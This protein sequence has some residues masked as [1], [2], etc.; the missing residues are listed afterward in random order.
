MIF[1]GATTPNRAQI[2]GFGVWLS[3]L[4]AVLLWPVIS[5]TGLAAQDAA[6]GSTKLETGIDYPKPDFGNTETIRFLTDS[7]Y[8]PFNYLDEEGSLGGFNVDLARAICEELV[9][10][11]DVRAGDWV[12]LIATLERKDTDAII[13]SIRATPKTLEKLDFT[14]SYYRTPARFIV[15]KDSKLEDMDPKTLVGRSIAVVKDTGHAA[16]LKDFFTESE[17]TAFSNVRQAKVAL[18]EKK[19]EILFGDGISLM[20]WI[21]G[22]TSEGCC[23]FRGGPFLESRYFGEGVGIAL[24]KG[25][26]KMRAILN[27]GLAR[28]RA[29]GR[30]E[31]LYL[32]YFPL[33]VF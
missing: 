22:T 7:D 4:A 5:A 17:I 6:T 19:V 24:R 21:N 31:E 27:Y 18:K 1:S 25:D 13:A 11:C 2:P 8:P 30:L 10:E 32:R 26:R 9:M 16:F 15:R 20:Y 12:E 28:V 3:C 14:D 23:E 33:S 29:S